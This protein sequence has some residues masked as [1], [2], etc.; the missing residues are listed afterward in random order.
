MKV[1]YELKALYIRRLYLNNTET[2]PFDFHLCI[3]CLSIG[4]LIDE[5]V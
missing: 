5:R 3:N 2:A 4:L 1:L